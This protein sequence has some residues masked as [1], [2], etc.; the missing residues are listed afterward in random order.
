MS[1]KIVKLGSIATTSGTFAM[2]DVDYLDGHWRGIG[3]SGG[4]WFIDFDGPD[5]EWLANRHG[6]Q[7][8]VELA[9]GT[10][11]IKQGNRDVAKTVAAQA[12]RYIDRQDAK[13]RITVLPASCSRLVAADAARKAGV[14]RFSED[15]ALSMLA[16]DGLDVE[17]V[18]GDDG[19]VIELR[20]RPR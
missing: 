3:A 4:H 11:R 6:R 1:E 14:G 10:W 13:T 16:P 12:K 8:G 9:D 17:A 20:L 2:A 19:K 18:L 15:R 5:A 7:T